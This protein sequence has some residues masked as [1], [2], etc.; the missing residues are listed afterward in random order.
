MRACNDSVMSV[1]T[2]KQDS[3]LVGS[4]DGTVRIFD[5]RMGK[6]VV[7]L[8]HHPVTCVSAT[9]DDGCILAACTDGHIRLLDRREGDLLNVYQGHVHKST[10]LDAAFLPSDA[11]IV[12][13]SEDGRVVYWDVVEGSI[14]GEVQAH[15]NQIVCSLSVSPQ[16]DCLL[17]SSVDGTVKL[18]TN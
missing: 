13:C 10:K 9:A 17:T 6:Q 4:V 18:W 12:S 7:D 3:I 8:V 5:V 1:M 11:H 16:G 2:L 15:N 14:L